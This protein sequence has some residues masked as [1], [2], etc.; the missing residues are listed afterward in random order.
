MHSP[1]QHLS[2]TPSGFP[3]QINRGHDGV[4][5]LLKPPK[6]HYNAFIRK[7]PNHSPEYFTES[8]VVQTPL[9]ERA[10]GVR[11]RLPVFLGHPIAA[12]FSPVFQ[13]RVFFSPFSP[14]IRIHTV[15]LGI[16]SSNSRPPIYNFCCHPLCESGERKHFVRFAPRFSSGE[17]SSWPGRC[18][19]SI[20]WL[21]R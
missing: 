11:F 15:F 5:S 8:T 10:A 13:F 19:R 1:L 20:V 21:C 18:R 17:Q 3:E 2:A 6:K 12:L 9:K 4:N 7:Q 14:Y 16:F